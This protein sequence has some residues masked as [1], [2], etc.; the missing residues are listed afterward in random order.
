MNYRIRSTGEV[1][2]Q[3]EIR[4]IHSNTSLPRVWDSNVC[5]ALGIDPVFETPKPDTTG[6]THAIRNG[7][8]QDANGNWVQAW[9][10]VDMFQDYTDDEGVTHTKAEQEAAYQAKLNEG[11]F[12]SIQDATQQRLDDFARTRNYD[13]MLSLCTYATSSNVKFQAEGL[14]GVDLR[15]A[16]WSKLY[17]ILAEIEAGT[18]PIP[19]AYSD[20]EGELPALVWPN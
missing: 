5:D 11:I 4:K 18:R 17:E 20:I 1:K 13:G 15:D 10:V 6:Y 8:T 12:T 19:S 7:V 3:G 2:S 14:Y 16:T 9:T